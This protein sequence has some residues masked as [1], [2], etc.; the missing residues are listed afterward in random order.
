MPETQPNTLF[1]Q[2]MAAIKAGQ[3]DQAQDILMQVVC[4]D[5]LNEQAW[6]WLAG[7]VTDMKQTIQCLEKVLALNPDN[8]PAR[9]WL[10]LARLEQGG[11]ASN[12]QAPSQERPVAHLGRYLLEHGMITARQLEAALQAQD[13]AAKKGIEK[14]VGEILVEQGVITEQHLHFAVQE[15]NRDLQDLFID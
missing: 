15:Q 14:K 9:D 11:Q 4:A 10:A 7:V 1:E 5:P 6:F 3:E 13:A 8:T 12:V 2:A